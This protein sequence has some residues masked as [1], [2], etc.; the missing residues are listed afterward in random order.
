MQQHG[1]VKGR[2]S[3]GGGSQR[4][5]PHGRNGR[6]VRKV[7]APLNHAAA[8]CDRAHRGRGARQPSCIARQ[9]DLP[10]WRGRVDW[11]IGGGSR[12]RTPPRLTQVTATP[13]AAAEA[14]NFTARLRPNPRLAPVTTASMVMVWDEA[15]LVR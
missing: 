15:A 5:P 10:R 4:V 13:R 3:V 11:V 7:D 9:Q 6:Q 12:P 8:G 2:R 14:A 1:A